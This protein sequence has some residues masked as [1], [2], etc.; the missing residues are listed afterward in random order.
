MEN[1]LSFSSL[2]DQARCDFVIYDLSRRICKIPN[3]TFIDIEANRQ[4]YP[5]PIQQKA[6]LAIA[7]WQDK[8]APWI[9]FLNFPLDERGLLNQAIFRF[10]SVGC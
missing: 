7:Y 9:W 8:N 6:Q 4:A 3:Q 5:Y 1:P 2:F 10:Y